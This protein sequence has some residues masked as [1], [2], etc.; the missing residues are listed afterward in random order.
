M[1][2]LSGQNTVQLVYDSDASSGLTTV[3]FK[4]AGGTELGQLKIETLRLRAVL[5][6]MNVAAA[7]LFPD[8]TPNLRRARTLLDRNTG[9]AKTVF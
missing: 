4:D 2:D 6:A 5:A 8:M 7:E 3:T 9:V 1:I